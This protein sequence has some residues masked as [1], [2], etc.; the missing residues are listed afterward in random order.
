MVADSLDITRQMTA[1]L[2][3]VREEG[4]LQ[5]ELKL[6]NVEITLERHVKVLGFGLAKARPDEELIERFDDR[7]VELDDL[8]STL[9][10]TKNLTN[11]AAKKDVQPLKKR[12]YWSQSTGAAIPTRMAKGPCKP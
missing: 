7:S 3:A 4:T 8:E 5:R 11:K 1:A 6:A 9:A 2:E 12:R 10:E